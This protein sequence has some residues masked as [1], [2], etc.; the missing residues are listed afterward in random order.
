M[1]PWP[2]EDQAVRRMVCSVSTFFVSRAVVP[3]TCLP[4]WPDEGDQAVRRMVRSVSTCFVP[5]TAGTARNASDPALLFRRFLFLRA[6]R[7]WTGGCVPP[8]PEED[9][10]VHRMVCSVSTFFVSNTRAVVPERCMP[11]WPDQGDQ[12]VRRMVRSVST[13]FVPG[14]AGTA[15]NASDPALLFRRFLFLRAH[16]RW[17]GGCRKCSPCFSYS[18]NTRR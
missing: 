14:T 12:A 8:W 6:H 5:E 9:Q 17:A 18:S 16:R 11:P 13:C 4:P 7:R 1:P 2:Q 3:E 10:A 15:R